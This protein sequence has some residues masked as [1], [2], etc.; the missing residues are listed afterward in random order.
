MLRCKKVTGIGQREASFVPED[1]DFWGFAQRDAAAV[2]AWRCK[3]PARGAVGCDDD[4]AAVAA[5]RP[6]FGHD[7]VGG[8]D[9][10]LARKPDPSADF[11]R[12]AFAD[13]KLARAG[14]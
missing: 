2:H 8:A 5:H 1:G 12:D 4:D 13:E 10:I 7:G 14:C 11:V 6:Y 9:D 3:A